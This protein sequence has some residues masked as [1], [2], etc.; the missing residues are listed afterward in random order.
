MRASYDSLF[1]KTRDVLKK[2]P[3]SGHLFVLSIREERV[4]SVFTMMA[5]D[6]L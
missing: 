4:V 3:L 2:D 1:S 5:Q 6:S